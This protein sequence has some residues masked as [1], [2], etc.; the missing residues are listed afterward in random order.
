MNANL[1]H[2][3]MSDSKFLSRPQ[4]GRHDCI[5]RVC[6][7]AGASIALAIGDHEQRRALALFQL[8]VLWRNHQV[9]TLHVL[10]EHVVDLDSLLLNSRRC[11][12]DF[13]VEL[14]A[15]ATAG[16]GHPAEVVHLLA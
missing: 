11:D 12:V 1:D 4:Q 9:L 15:D 2:L 5:G 8:L 13:I 3:L 16:P 6:V 14:D 7:D 10:H